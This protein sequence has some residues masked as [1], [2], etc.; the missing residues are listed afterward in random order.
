MKSSEKIV[1]VE[2]T[3][4]LHEGAVY[5]PKKIGDGSIVLFNLSNMEFTDKIYSDLNEVKQEFSNKDTWFIGD[6]D[7]AW[8]CR[9]NVISNGTV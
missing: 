5:I 4:K 9:F 7:L 8:T 1:I 3:R 2:K 6:T